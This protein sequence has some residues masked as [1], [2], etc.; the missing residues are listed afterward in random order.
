[1]TFIAGLATLTLSASHRPDLWSYSWEAWRDQQRNV[2]MSA[3]LEAALPPR[4]VVLGFLHTGVIAD[5]TGRSIVRL[6]LVEPATL[7]SLVRELGAYG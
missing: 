5:R 3:Y 7:E 4:A 2:S 1:M 6:D